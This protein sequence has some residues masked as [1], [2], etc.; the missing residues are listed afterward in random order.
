MEMNTE[1]RGKQS[2]NNFTN[3]VGKGYGRE[4]LTVKLGDTGSYSMAVLLG[5]LLR[6]H[7]FAGWSQY[8]I[9]RDDEEV[10]FQKQQ[11][12][13]FVSNCESDF[14]ASNQDLPVHEVT[15]DTSAQRVL[16]ENNVHETFGRKGIRH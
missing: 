12:S 13:G 5:H 7:P 6:C 1:G 10:L 16:E 2:F 14:A 11:G 3:T 4:S 15:S 9:G 8:K